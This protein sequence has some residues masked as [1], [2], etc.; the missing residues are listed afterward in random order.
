MYNKNESSDDSNESNVALINLPPQ[1]IV[2]FVADACN[3]H[4]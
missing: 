3:G 2:R 4:K 1:Q